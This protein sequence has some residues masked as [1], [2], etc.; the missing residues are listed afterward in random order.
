M[1]ALH[2][3]SSSRR[4]AQP[5]VF[6]ALLAA[7]FGC[8]ADNPV[9]P[10]PMPTVGIRITPE[11]DT[12]TVGQFADFSTTIAYSDGTSVDMLQ[13]YVTFSVTPP[14]LVLVPSTAPTGSVRLY[15]RV[16]GVVTLTADYAGPG[17]S[18]RGAATRA[19]RQIRIVPDPAFPIPEVDRRAHV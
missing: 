5:F 15:G 18:Y 9:A 10:P 12:I 2:R 19:S 8:G 7:T 17:A 1:G 6:V 4:L 3:R 16:P 14:E 13:N 11:T